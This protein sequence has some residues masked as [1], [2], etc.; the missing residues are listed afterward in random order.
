M[1]CVFRFLPEAGVRA[2]GLG[3]LPLPQLIIDSLFVIRSMMPWH[4]QIPAWGSLDARVDFTVPVEAKLHKDGLGIRSRWFTGGLGSSRKS[5][6]EHVFLG[7]PREFCDS[8]TCW[9]RSGIGSKSLTPKSACPFK[10]SGYEFG[11]N[12]PFLGKP[13][14]DSRYPHLPICTPHCRLDYFSW[15]IN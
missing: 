1:M 12:P 3:P 14:I 2:R 4:R 13:V 9:V 10:I 5:P 6:V 8:I 15:L 11:T 7:F